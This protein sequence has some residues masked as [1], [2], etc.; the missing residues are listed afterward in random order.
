VYG[1]MWMLC[2]STETIIEVFNRHSVQLSSRCKFLFVR[3]FVIRLLMV[4]PNVP[5]LAL[6]A[7]ISAFNLAS[8][9][10]AKYTRRRRVK[11]C[12]D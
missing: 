8:S 1:S 6:F 2:G 11:S 5:R 4:V 3:L 10:F 12:T 7:V 9:L